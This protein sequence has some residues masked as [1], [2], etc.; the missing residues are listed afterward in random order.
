MLSRK[1]RTANYVT[2]VTFSKKHVKVG[3]DKNLFVRASTQFSPIQHLLQCGWQFPSGVCNA[4]GESKFI[5]LSSSSQQQNSGA[6]ST[7][8]GFCK[9]RRERRERRS[10]L[11]VGGEAMQ[12]WDNSCLDAD[13]GPQIEAATNVAQQIAKLTQST[14]LS[15][16]TSALALC[17]L[18]QATLN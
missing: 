15:E 5:S 3:Q 14:R 7:L 18:S 13:E 2:I 12:N 17:C 16:N 11:K 10:K 4:A 8:L 1:M 9:V 6:A